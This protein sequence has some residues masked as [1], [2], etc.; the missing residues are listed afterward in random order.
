MTP[1]T[2]ARQIGVSRQNIQHLLA[3]RSKNPH[4]LQALARA[5]GYSTDDLLALRAPP[6]F[7]VSISHSNSGKRMLSQEYSSAVPFV[8]WR[9]IGEEILLKNNQIE[10]D[11][12]PSLLKPA[13]SGPRVKA[14]T[15]PDDSLAGELAI[16]TIVL[17]DPDYAPADGDVVLVRMLDDS[18]HLRIYRKLADGSFDVEATAPRLQIWNSLKHGLAVTATVIGEFRDRRRAA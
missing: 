12:G 1:T 13:N 14:T 8:L 15:V 10:A 17:L 16:G 7:G 3:G 9:R 4:Y 2:L 11:E 6:A 18:Q 5:M